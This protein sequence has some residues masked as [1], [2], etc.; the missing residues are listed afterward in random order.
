MSETQK[1]PL[2]VTILAILSI[3]LG[4]LAI[5]SGF[6]GIGVFSE[7][8]WTFMDWRIISSE[9][10]VL[11]LLGVLSIIVGILSLPAG[12]GLLKGKKWAWTLAIV[13]GILGVIRNL[14]E[15]ALENVDVGTV[16]ISIVIIVLVIAY[17]MKPSTK[18][19]CSK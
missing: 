4:L 10:E 19:F 12:Y 17:L 3:L 6:G 18:A 1:R 11:A 16:I 2:G 7:L 13:L 8:F 9:L 15:L 5:V 14:V